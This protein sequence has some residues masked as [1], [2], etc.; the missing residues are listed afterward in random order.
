MHE[1]L[2]RISK[3]RESWVL[4]IDFLVL[5]K[6][7]MIK[8]YFEI[9]GEFLRYQSIVLSDN[10]FTMI[11]VLDVSIPAKVIQLLFVLSFPP[12]TD[13]LED[14]FQRAVKNVITTR[15]CKIFQFT[16]SLGRTDLSPLTSTSTPLMLNGGWKFFIFRMPDHGCGKPHKLR[17]DFFKFRPKFST[18]AEK[19]QLLKYKKSTYVFYRVQFALFQIKL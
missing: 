3:V 18:R 16:R 14:Y 19:S 5:Y 4:Q 17:Q 7:S 15:G 2:S 8:I 10:Y 13:D 9:L 12:P 6:H 1:N 11:V